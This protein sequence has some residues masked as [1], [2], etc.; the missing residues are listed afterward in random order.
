VSWSTAN[1]APPQFA[2][3]GGEGT[4]QVS[5][6]AR[7]VVAG[8]EQRRQRVT[9]LGRVT[10]GQVGQQGDRLAPADVHQLAI[11][12]D[13][14][15]AEEV[16]GQLGHLCLSCFVERRYGTAGFRDPGCDERGN[17]GWDGA[18]MGPKG[19]LDYST[20]PDHTHS[21]LRDQTRQ[22]HHRN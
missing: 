19:R 17:E 16:D 1:Q 22:I 11:Q 4:A 12:F 3:E 7:L 8:P 5:P 10:Q 9:T 14:W 18:A 13:A 2:G 20:F 21:T 6:R 15:R